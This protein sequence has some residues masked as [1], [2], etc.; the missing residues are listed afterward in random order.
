MISPLI[1]QIKSLIDPSLEADGFGVVHMAMINGADRKTLQ[2]MAENRKTGR[3]TLDECTQI[4][5][6]VSALLDVEDILDGAFNLEVSSPGIDRPLVK[7]EDFERFAGFDAKLESTLPIDGRRKF[8]GQLIGLDGNSVIM[9]IDNQDYRI[10]LNNIQ[11]A[12]L[13]LTDALIKAHKPA[14]EPQDS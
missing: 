12:K 14:S 7:R 8:K 3:I 6:T 4:N 9:R 10:D 2:I 5:R 13:V 1:E 11:Q